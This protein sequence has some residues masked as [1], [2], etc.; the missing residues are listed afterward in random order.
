MLFPLGFVPHIGTFLL[1][2]ISF[3]NNYLYWREC[4]F[5]Y[6]LQLV[7]QSRRFP[8]GAPL[9]IQN[10]QSQRIHICITKD[11]LNTGRSSYFTYQF[12]PRYLS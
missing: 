1:R 5:S 3:V 2:I 11:H 9:S 8:V 12:W 10:L 6:W 4:P 7:F